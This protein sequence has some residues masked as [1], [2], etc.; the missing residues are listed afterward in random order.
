MVSKVI[1]S[2]DAWLASAEKLLQEQRQHAISP[3][4]VPCGDGNDQEW[5]ITLSSLAEGL[6]GLLEDLC[7]RPGRWILIVEDERRP[8]LYWQALAFEDGSLVAE[9]VSNFYLDSDHHWST[10]QESELTN[11]GW[12][13]PESPRSTNWIKVEAST[14]PETDVVAR[15]A[16]ATLGTV[17]ELKQ[18][19]CLRVK[20]FSSPRR[21]NTPASAHYST[22]DQA[23]PHNTVYGSRSGDNETSGVGASG[24]G[25]IRDEVASY[26]GNRFI[27]TTQPWAD[28]Y[29]AEFPG[30]VNPSSGFSA[31][32]YASTAINIVQTYWQSRE[33]ARVEWESAHGLDPTSWP[34]G[35]PPVVLWIPSCAKAACLACTWIDGSSGS[36]LAVAGS[37]ARSHAIDHGSNARIVRSLRVPISQRKG[38]H[39]SL[40]EMWAGHLR[41]LQRRRAFQRDRVA[42]FAA[43]G[44]GTSAPDGAS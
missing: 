3:T 8:H 18:A 27:P 4:L 29:R 23:S 28:Y 2:L 30:H 31:W 44:G 37:N 15:R 22:E 38:Q 20:L 6:P 17:F 25:R 14:M 16:L 5:T 39:E 26:S 42:G 9:V 7:A 19:A 13:R 40:E 12:E 43:R 10:Q 32:K 33:R 21:G 41:V 36:D 35:H 24:T 1:A 11:L 34:M